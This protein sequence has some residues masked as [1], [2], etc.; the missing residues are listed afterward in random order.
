MNY[1]NE[2]GHKGFKKSKWTA[3]HQKLLI[4]LLA[5]GYSRPDIFRMFQK[6]EYLQEHECKVIDISIFDINNHARKVTPGQLKAAREKLEANSA[7]IALAQ[8]LFRVKE[9][10]DI[11]YKLKSE[12]ELSADK[13]DLDKISQLQHILRDIKAE[14][15]EEAYNAALAHSGS[16]IVA[17]DALRD[18]LNSG[19]PPDSQSEDKDNS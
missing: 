14:I 5:Q 16:G 10:S 1:N 4:S 7:D 11:Y 18:L 13:V 2:P 9:L 17:G 19:T 6:P 8:K 3:K 12:Y 15:G